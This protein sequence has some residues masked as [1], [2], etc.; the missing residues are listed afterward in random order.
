MSKMTQAD[1]EAYLGKSA[2][3][4]YG[5]ISPE[6]Y[7]EYIIPLLFFKRISD[8]YDE[9]T[10]KALDISGGDE[11]FAA[12]PQHHSFQIPEG[13]HWIDVRSKLLML[14]LQSTMPS[15]LLKRRM[16]KSWQAYLAQRLVGQTRNCSRIA[17]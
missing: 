17:Y 5:V 10:Q 13:A 2:N 9:E 14:V 11:E 12:F 16:L 6:H 7:K 8:M 1:L 15:V 3:I 4:L